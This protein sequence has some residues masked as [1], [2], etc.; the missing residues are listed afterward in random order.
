MRRST[1]WLLTAAVPAVAIGAPPA[2]A[3]TATPQ[4]D[5]CLASNGLA[6]VPADQAG[7]AVQICKTVSVTKV[8]TYSWSLA[9]RADPGEVQLAL[10]QSAPLVA[11]VL[12][13]PTSSTQWIV[14]GEIV[15]RHTDPQ[16]AT[17]TSI[18]DALTLA[19]GTTRTETVTSQPFILDAAAGVPERT[20]HY[21]FTIADPALVAG[22]GANRARVEWAQGLIDPVAEMTVPV[23]FSG[24]SVATA[25][26]FR[27]AA[28]SD[29]LDAA[30]PGLIVA[31]PTSAGSL[32]LSADDPASLTHLITSGVRN[33]GLACGASTWIPDTATLTP[34]SAEPETTGSPTLPDP[35]PQPAAVSAHA[36]VLVRGPACAQPVQLPQGVVQ[37]I[38]RPAKAVP[39]TPS[40]PAPAMRVTIAVPSRLVAGRPTV[41]ALRL[42]N[43]GRLPLRRAVLESTLPRGVALLGSSRRYAFRAGAVR[44][45]VGALAPGAVFTARMTVKA[46]RTGA[47]P[48]L[49]RVRALSQC[50]QTA[51][52][53]A[54]LVAAP[55]PVVA[56]AVTG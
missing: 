10:E 20:V 16:S 41:L 6:S 31:P 32:A 49:V 51:A 18:T 38:T 12:A 42:E 53:R 36:Q 35:A 24:S 1:W 34:A 45:P 39:S 23:G 11:T 19:D 56:P 28:V 40:C 27:T 4:F 30:P 14:A 2:A 50:G 17:V 43:R 9:K 7:L 54:V 22:S 3:G 46:S 33:V 48:G 15:V 25:S 55:R 21:R 13:I 8:T 44:L 52:V 5:R 47:G 29:M 26:Y 37:G